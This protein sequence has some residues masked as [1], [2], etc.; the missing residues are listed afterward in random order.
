[1]IRNRH[2]SEKCKFP[3]FRAIHERHSHCHLP[4]SLELLSYIWDCL[5]MSTQS[6]VAGAVYVLLWHFSYPKHRWFTK[7][8]ILMWVPPVY[9][10][11]DDVLWRHQCAN[12]YSITTHVYVWCNLN[13]GDFWNNFWNCVVW[14]TVKGDRVYPRQP[15]N[16][17]TWVT[18][19]S[20]IQQR[21]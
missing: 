17:V 20:A 21:K 14:K 1:M 19:K 15:K 6:A 12:I 9:L 10:H 7:S 8:Y 4:S 5:T 2:H 13:S 11:T 18:W 16:V 3:N